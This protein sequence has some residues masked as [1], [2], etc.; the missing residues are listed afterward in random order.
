[1]VL[2]SVLLVIF[3]FAVF[4]TFYYYRTVLAWIKDPATSDEDVVDPQKRHAHGVGWR[5]LRLRGQGSR[6]QQLPNL[7]SHSLSSPPP[8]LPTYSSYHR[9]RALQHQYQQSQHLENPR[10]Q[11][12]WL[13]A[14]D[15]NSRA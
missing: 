14:R 1:M 15:R 7:Q 11:R 5:L 3:G 10:M 4:I 6:G 9:H 2:L 8:I 13:A 12:P